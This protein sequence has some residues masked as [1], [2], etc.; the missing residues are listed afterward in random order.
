MENLQKRIL[1]QLAQNVGLLS[2][3][4]LASAL[5]ESVEDVRNV[6]TALVRQKKVK[7]HHPGFGELAYSLSPEAAAGEVTIHP[8]PEPKLSLSDRIRS[9]LAHATEPMTASQVAEALPEETEAKVRNAL[10]NAVH[11][12]EVVSSPVGP[13]RGKSFALADGPGADAIATAT[14]TATATVTAKQPTGRSH[15]REPH[16]DAAREPAGSLP[17][18]P[19]EGADVFDH[20]VTT[21]WRAL[22]AYVELTADAFVYGWLKQS[23]HA[24]E[25]ARVE[26]RRLAN[27]T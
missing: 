17:D 19:S 1:D 11:R 4:D 21:A 24:A 6:L 8:M 27:G 3:H 12:R 16:G 15:E 7:R 23:V 9:I 13:G 10:Y 14:A 20:A 26:A 5:M 2:A 18:V 25:A 22:D